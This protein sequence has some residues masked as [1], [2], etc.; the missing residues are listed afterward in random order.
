MK[1]FLV[2]AIAAG[3]LVFAAAPRSEAQ[4]YF[5]IGFGFPG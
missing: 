5:S 1:R 4:V 2:I 3:G